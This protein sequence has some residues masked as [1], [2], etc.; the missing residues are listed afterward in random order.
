MDLIPR[1]E[2]FEWELTCDKTFE[3]PF[4]DVELQACFLSGATSIT[5]D[6][7]YDGENTWR[8]RFAPPSEGDW[9]AETFSNAAQL[10]GQ[11]T[12][13]QCT[14][15]ASRGGLAVN[16]QFPNWF[17]RQDG[18]PQ[19]VVNDGWY[20][21]PLFNFRLDFED[22]DFK[23]PSEEDIYTYLRILG[24][25]KVNMTIEVDQ[26]YA[27]QTSI[28]DISFNWPW[29]V[30][31]AKAN[32][33]DKD[34]FNLDFYRRMDRTLAFAKQQGVFYGFELLFD[35]S[36]FRP[37]EWSNHP[38]NID[39]GGWL[40]GNDRLTG[41]GV[42][43]NLKNEEHVKYI[44]RYLKYTV[45]RLAAYWNIYWALGAESGNIAKH[46][47]DEF[48]GEDIAAWYGYWGDYVAG[49]DPYGRLQSIGDTGELNCLVCHARNNFIITQEHTSMDDLKEFCKATNTFGE[50]FWQYARPCI[51]GEQDRHNLN[52]YDTERKGF[53][54]A[55][56]SGFYMGRVD[57]HFGVADQ[58][59]L[60]E[61]KLFH[62]NGVPPIYRDLKHMTNFVEQSGIRYWRMRPSDSL[63][64]SK[65]NENI[66]CLAEEDSG[67]LVYF[68][69][70]GSA[71][72]TIPEAKCV[73]FNP[74][75]GEFSKTFTLPGGRQT[76]TTPGDSDWALYI[77]AVP[78]HE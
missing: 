24:E 66:F 5:V 21:H 25:H 57:R 44:R 47:G 16:S 72:I 53:W 19:W 9:T 56:A 70:G 61:S 13:F 28:E 75:T 6:G 36:V 35:N 76:F 22:L 64:S 69:Q 1:W 59:V 33:I 32:K 10:H 27:R 3:N 48:P 39:N 30:V 23:K 8:V 29:K 14:K 37:R 52:K 55:F 12:A 58:G 73:W 38:L 43:F 41:W 60:V 51:I 74:G 2:I 40:E 49:K 71:A 50:R 31:D 67:Y 77:C 20:P 46:P 34:R 45:A 26:L 15:P 11:K 42:I 62:I 18:M 65:S 78:V 17:F 7:F 4:L 68:A 54:V 63:L